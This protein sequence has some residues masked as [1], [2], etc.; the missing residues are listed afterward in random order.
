MLI[1]TDKRN[2]NA[3]SKAK[4]LS[5]NE[6]SE[7][8]RNF[9]QPEESSIQDFD[10][11]YT[12]LRNKIDN[13]K[14]ENA[15]SEKRNQIHDDYDKRELQLQKMLADI[16]V[17]G[18][19]IN[20]RK[21]ARVTRLLVLAAL[22]SSLVAAGVFG[23]KYLHQPQATSIQE[24]LLSAEQ[25]A[26]LAQIDTEWQNFKT[27]QL[28]RIEESKNKFGAEMQKDKPD[29]ALVAAYERE[30]LEAKAALSAARTQMLLSKKAATV[31]E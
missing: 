11:F 4:N 16:D 25:T 19:T 30:L 3:K 31:A 21:V 7:L 22:A 12:Q 23:Y 26:Q 9:Y 24:P 29:S 8:L 20:R 5:P 1:M 18:K 28:L 17:S 10:E 13:T 14:F 15:A 6:V 2:K 27:Q